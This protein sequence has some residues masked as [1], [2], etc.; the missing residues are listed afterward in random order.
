MLEALTYHVSKRWLNLG[1]AVEFLN[2]KRNATTIEELGNF[3]E[4][5]IDRI[6]TNFVVAVRFFFKNVFFFLLC[7]QAFRCSKTEMPTRF[8]TS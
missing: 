4:M 5:D 8:N 6:E 1:T 7:G 2:I 3:K